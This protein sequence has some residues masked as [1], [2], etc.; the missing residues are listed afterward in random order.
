M[1]N[2]LLTKITNSIRH[3]GVAGA[4][5]RAV[6]RA[7]GIQPMPE[8]P[9]QRYPQYYKLL[10]GKKGLEI[11]GP[12]RVFGRRGELPV[13]PIVKGLD[14]C[15]FSTHTVWEGEIA[16][17]NSYRYDPA[18]PPG[19]QYISEASDLGP[20][21]S[22]SYD[23]VLSSHSLEHL[24]NP[25]KA[26]GEWTRVLKKNGILLIIVPDPRHTFDH[27]R[28][29]TPFAHLLEDYANGT[30]EHDLTHLEEILSL[31][32]LARD[33]LAGD[34]AAFRQRS[35]QNFENRCLH[36]HVFDAAL[37]GQVLG[38]HHVDVMATDWAAPYHTIVVGK[39]R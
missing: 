6:T 11:G 35:L 25:L 3:R 17:G 10:K 30:D 12:S 31:H 19:H 20:V 24:A 5:V 4:A 22:E 23:F 33:P 28:H 14:G 21:P 16:A 7:L 37:V 15:N 8:S 2:Q 1:A 34:R 13:Y 38:Y 39:K 29:V 32:D 26:V 36:H 9:L 18:R 27:R